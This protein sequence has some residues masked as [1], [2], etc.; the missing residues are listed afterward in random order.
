MSGKRNLFKHIHAETPKMDQQFVDFKKSLQTNGENCLAASPKCF[1]V[2]MTGGGGPCMVM[3]HTKPKR[4][5]GS[6]P[7]CNVHKGKL[8]DLQFSPFNDTLLASV[9]DDCMGYITNVAPL[10]EDDCKENLTKASV[11]LKGHGKKVHL[12]KFHPTANN[13]LATSSWDKTLKVWDVTTSEAVHTINTEKLFSMDWNYD[14]SLMAVANDKQK[15]QVYDPRTADQIVHDLVHSEGKKTSKVFWAEKQGYIGVT[16]FNKQA[17][18]CLRLWDL[19]NTAKPIYDEIID[20]SSSVAMPFYDPEANLLFLAGKGDSSIAVY[21]LGGKA[22]VTQLTKYGDTTPQKGGGWVPKRGLSTGDCEIARY[23]KVTVK[24]VVPLRFCVPRKNKEIFQSDL[25]EGGDN[26]DEAQTFAGLPSMS[27]SEYL[28]GGNKA[29]VLTCM[30][31]AKRGD[32]A[33]AEFVAKKSYAEL[34]EENEE[35]KK[36]IEELEKKLEAAS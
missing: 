32:Q 23:L 14:G 4:M 24:S 22:K 8:N 26:N 31:P 28:E 27:A 34:A 12:L 5:S 6:E 13:V 11:T 29:P 15:L 21:S 19:K 9:G 36:K 20:Q 30:D 16:C 35:L 18:R 25:Y 10:L 17:K 1:A 7:F 2:A 33:Q 3:D